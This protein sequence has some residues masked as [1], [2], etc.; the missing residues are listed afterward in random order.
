MQIKALY[1]QFMLDFKIL[2]DDEEKLILQAYT[3][4]GRF[5]ANWCLSKISYSYIN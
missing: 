3:E 1:K 4:K 2:V 5:Y